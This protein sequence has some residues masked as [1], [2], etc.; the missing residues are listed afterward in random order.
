MSTALC[1]VALGALIAWLTPLLLRVQ[2]SHGAAPRLAVL[3]WFSGASVAITLWLA[4]AIRLIL[5]RHLVA[6]LAG[7]ALAIAVSGRL[8]WTVVRTTRRTR[9]RQ[10]DHLTTARL[11][12]RTDVRPGVLVIDARQPAVYC[13]PCDPATDAGS[14]AGAGG[15]IVMSSGAHELLSEAEAQAVFVHE[16]THL[17]ERHDLIVTVAFALQAAFPLFKPFSG[18]GTEVARLLEMRADDAAVRTHGR[19][20]VIDALAS[21]CLVDVPAGT[22]AAHGPSVLQRV[23]RLTNPASRWRSRISVAT[24]AM[25]VLVLTAVPVLGPW[26]PLCPHPII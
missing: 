20:T 3:A 26:L 15:T 6:Q 23:H 4:A 16:R 9:R 11:I 21:L 13:V 2:S 22:M 1:L 10:R 7:A 14:A 5:D 18:M 17:H 25:T 19:D 8:A 24:T 12:G